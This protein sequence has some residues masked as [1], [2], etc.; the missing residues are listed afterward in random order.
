MSPSP[1]VSV[2]MS[3]YN[4]EKY[5]AEAI[6]SILN[7]TFSDFEF[8]IIDDGSTDETEA[9]L[10]GFHNSRIIRC[11]N[12]QN[13]GLTRSLNKGLEMAR[14]EYI[15]RMDADDV[16]FPKRLAKQV[17]FLDSHTDIGV[18]GTGIQLVDELGAPGATMLFP[19]EP[20]VIKW[21]LF[22]Y[23]PIVHP[24]VMI[25]RT[26]YERFDGY[27][28]DLPYVEDYDL[29]L[30]ITPGIKIANL[31]DVLLGL[32]KHNES[33]TNVRRQVHLENAL[34]AAQRAVSL[35]L[36]QQVSL[37]R[38]RALRRPRSITTAR[39]MLDTAT[40]IRQLYLICTSDVSTLEKKKIRKDAAN[41]LLN[42]AMVCIRIN[43]GFSM[44]IGGWAIRLSPAS[45]F[46]M[47]VSTANRAVRYLWRHLVLTG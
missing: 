23:C 31:P 32:R 7:Q 8:I 41:K 2:V 20:G 33:V 44:L 21:Q 35:A 34:R 37:D 38:V 27:S 3:V 40:L 36:G 43:P 26:V 39:G 5:L 30:R 16:S 10:D 25:R 19:T 4:G 29:W 12:E 14:G 15:A 11:K 6:E 17:D 47:V 18:L 1:L 28:P 13:I 24:S 42:L 9:I 46:R 22:F 45:L